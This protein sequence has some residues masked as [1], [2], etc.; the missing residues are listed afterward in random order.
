MDK[1]IDHADTLVRL[2][3]ARWRTV[4]PLVQAWE[5][6]A[7]MLG[8]PAVSE[9]MARHLVER[10][11]K[12]AIDLAVFY[13]DPMA[14]RSWSVGPQQLIDGLTLARQ[15]VPA[16]LALLIH[17]V[18]LQ[19]AYR[20]LRQELMVYPAHDPSVLALDVLLAG[21]AEV[22]VPVPPGLARLIRRRA[23]TSD[24][25]K[26]QPD[27][28]D[29]DRCLTAPLVV[30]LAVP[31]ALR[32]AVDRIARLNGRLEL[33]ATRLAT[34]GMR[35]D[36][37]RRGE[38]PVDETLPRTDEDRWVDTRPTLPTMHI[39][40]PMERLTKLEQEIV[41]RYADGSTRRAIAGDLAISAGA[42]S[43][44]LGRA[45]T[46]STFSAVDALVCEAA[47]LDNV[48]WASVQ[49]LLEAVTPTRGKVTE[50]S[51]RGGGPRPKSNRLIV[52]A[53]I[54]AC[55][56]GLDWDGLSR[57]PTWL[58]WDALAR[59]SPMLPPCGLRTV[60]RRLH[61]WQDDATWDRVQG[62]LTPLLRG[63]APIAWSRARPGDIG[64]RAATMNLPE[65]ERVTRLLEPALWLVPSNPPDATR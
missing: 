64:T 16:P 26:P 52:A 56:T 5:D 11:G 10:V 1:A 2:Y 35:R 31:P 57:L 50:P 4:L 32:I 47:G 60:E 14:A 17:D 62:R 65:I 19:G 20:I 3:A 41:A 38:A 51:R 15:T 27:A 30:H 61:A 42:V 48:A 43:G 33:L 24:I 40:I 7:A 18:V 8:E 13:Q 6:L 63:S 55:R 58:G 22:D 46:N 25:P 59:P 44:V 53:I 45:R 23:R 29:L 39:S 28:V 9:A 36:M 49:T 34:W 37:L 12:L 21:L 54:I